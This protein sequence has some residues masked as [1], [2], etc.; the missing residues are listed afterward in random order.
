MRRDHVEILGTAGDTH[1]RQ[2]EKQAACNAQ[3]VTD[4]ERFVEVRIVDQPLP[5]NRSTR[6]LEI[7]THHD[8]KITVKLRNRLPQQSRIFP[9]SNRIVDGA[10]SD[11]DDQ[12]VV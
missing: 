10:G 6:F 1:L 5:A 12:A 7:H 11:N 9:G 2:I 4:T 3:T 8:Q